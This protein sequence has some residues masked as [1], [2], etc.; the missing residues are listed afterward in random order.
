[1]ISQSKAC[2]LLLVSLQTSETPSVALQAAQEDHLALQGLEAASNILQV[3]VKLRVLLYRLLGSTDWFSHSK[4]C[5][6]LTAVFESR[7]EKDRLVCQ[8]N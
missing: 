5:K 2:K 1:M 6:L 3:Y 7:L 8:C 4:A